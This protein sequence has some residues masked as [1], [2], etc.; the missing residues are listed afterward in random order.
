MRTLLKCFAT[1]RITT[2]CMTVVFT[3]ICSPYVPGCTALC[4][5][6]ALMLLLSSWPQVYIDGEFYGGCDIMISDFQSGALK[7]TVEKVMME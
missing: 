7:E 2:T 6:H 3:H 5:T 1:L 4:A